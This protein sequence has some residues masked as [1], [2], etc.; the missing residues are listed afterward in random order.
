MFNRE[1]SSFSPKETLISTAFVQL[2]LLPQNQIVLIKSKAACLA[3]D[4]VR[5]KF[6]AISIYLTVT[7]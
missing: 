2:A 7:A 4:Q 1:R 5:Q 6:V 3:I